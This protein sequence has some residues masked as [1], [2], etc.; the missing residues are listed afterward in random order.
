M[1]HPSTRLALCALAAALVI[2]TAMEVSIGPMSIPV[3]KLIP[4]TLAYLHGVR[5]G[6][7]VVM[8]AI[9]WPRALV[10]ILVGAGLASTGAVLQAV[11]RNSM[12]DP[13]VI[14]VSSG[15][16]LGAVLTIQVG[17]AKLNVW[18]TPVGAFLSG[19]VVVYVIY[20]LATLQGRTAIYALLL[21]GV[22]VSS[23][24]SAMVMLL[25]SLVP[26]QTMQ[27]MM[28][29]LMGG[30]DGTTWTSVWMVL[31]F[32]FAGLAVYGWQAQALDI[33]SIGEEQAEGLGVPIQTI[34]QILF[35][36]SALVVG[37]CVSVS[38]VI[39]FVGLI[40]PHLIRMWVGPRHRVLLPASALGGGILLAL[41]DLLGRMALQ[42]V[43][44]NVGVVTSCLGAPFFLYLLRRHYKAFERG[45]RQ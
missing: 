21:A 19:L 42:P 43:E 33:L 16:S 17:L 5:S 40:V 12:A 7:A 2:A 4:D 35:A 20:R 11:F 13:A 37:A 9:R 18:A 24:C 26:L 31:V 36:M 25:L 3:A 22:A 44:L 8:G 29:W 32:V 23:F 38:G 39:A 1:R 34:K 10:A 41:A 14:G 27:E 15:A 6:D 45:S 28:F 30:L